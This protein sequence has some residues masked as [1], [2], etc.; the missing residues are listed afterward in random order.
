[1]SRWWRLTGLIAVCI[2]GLLGTLTSIGAADAPDFTM[3]GFPTVAASMDVT[4]DQAVTLTAGPQSVAIMAGTFD[5]PVTFDLLTGTPAAWQSQVS[6]RT[7]RAAFAFRVTDKTTKAIVGMFKQ[8]VLYTY[9]GTDA[10]STDAI[11]NTSATTPPMITANATPITFDG[12]VH[13][14]FGGAGV[15]WLV[16]SALAGGTT[17]APTVAAPPSAPPPPTPRANFIRRLG[18]G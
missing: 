3:F 9:S 15:G 17:P 14:S 1:M 10:Q 18:D 8:P 13:H 6:G 16:A 2:F 12:K 7:V 4:P 11:L 5:H